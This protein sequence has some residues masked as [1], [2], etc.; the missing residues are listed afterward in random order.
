M[1]RCRIGCAVVALLLAVPAGA[2][3]I[4][5]VA[6][7]ELVEQAPLVVVARVVERGPT[8]SGTPATEYRF[9]VERVLK[10]AVGPELTLRVPGGIGADG[11][12][13]RIYGAPS[14]AA[15]E[16]AILFLESL[17]G[18][19]YRILHLMQGAFHEVRHEGR[20]LALRDFTD[21]TEMTNRAGAID[22]APAADAEPVRDFEAFSRWIAD[23]ARGAAPAADYRVSL[24]AAGEGSGRI[25]AP[26]NLF[27]DQ[28]TGL[29]LRWFEFDTGGS[30]DWFF[31]TAGQ[32]GVPGGGLNDFKSALDAWNADPQTPIRYVF[33]GT[34][35]AS[36]GL[37]GEDNCGFDGYDELNVILF[38]DPNDE[39]P[40]FSATCSGTLAYGGP[41]YGNETRTFRGQQYHRIL[42]ADI[43]INEGIECFFEGSPNAPKAA[44]QLFAHELGHTLGIDHPCG[45]RNGPD[46]N[47]ENP[48][49]NDALMR[50]F[51]HQDDRGAKLNSDDLAAARALYQQGGNSGPGSPPAAPAGLTAVPLSTSEIELVWQDRSNDETGFVIEVK[52]LGGTF[53]AVGTLPANSTVAEVFNLSPATGYVFRVRATNAEGTSAPTNEAQASTNTLPGSCVP[54]AQALCL[55]NGRFQVDVDWAFGDTSGKGQVVPNVASDNSG[56]FYIF[57]EANWELVVKVLDGCQINQRF[58]VFAGGLTNVQVLVRVVDTATGAVRHYFNPQNTAFQ[59]VQ[60]AG[61]FATCSAVPNI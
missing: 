39:L 37:C 53:E 61:A 46:P 57:Q 9:E 44:E 56:P 41:W 42:N 20:S 3:S 54:G 40:A 34:S 6:D 25:A 36:G 7:E 1:T 11:I 28:G 55:A 21:V 2:T 33:A 17:A 22:A 48:T 26:V 16:R 10:G 35:G 12:G 4:V 59:P 51:V 49:F 29:K 27:F 31:G 8:A 23:S 45:N 38:G 15:G 60:D 52:V 13:L 18:G 24:P 32:P 14:F 50:A 43:V 19:D 47:C 30:V 58:W 5:R